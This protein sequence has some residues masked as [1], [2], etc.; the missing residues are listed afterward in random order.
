MQHVVK[1]AGKDHAGIRPLR[2]VAQIHF[3]EAFQHLDQFGVGLLQVLVVAD[4]GAIFRHQ[5]AKF[6]P[7]PKRIFRS[8]IIHQQGIGFF[9]LFLFGLEDSAAI[10][11]S[12]QSAR[13]L[14]CIRTGD[15]AAVDA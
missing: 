6:L 4:D 1:L 7:Q 10:G 14:H 15:A 9:L 13:I 3:A 12:L 5:F 11:E 8:R 2:A